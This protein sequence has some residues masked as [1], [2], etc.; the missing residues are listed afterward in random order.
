MKLELKSLNKLVAMTILSASSLQASAFQDAPK[1]APP[2]KIEI[3]EKFKLHHAPKTDVAIRR[4]TYAG[5]WKAPTHYHNSDLFIYIMEGSFEVTME[6][7]GR[8][9]YPAGDA[10]RMA[11]ETVMDARNASESEQLI[12]VVFQVGAVDAP[13]VVPVK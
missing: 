5:G 10:M 11:P 1:Q 13:F 8:V 9:V 4:F 12:L 6:H 7:T 3:L 2:P